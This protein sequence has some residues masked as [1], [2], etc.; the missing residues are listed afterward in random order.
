MH[1]Q[2]AFY[3]SDVHTDPPRCIDRATKVPP[4][5]TFQDGVY[6]NRIAGAMGHMQPIGT[7]FRHPWTWAGVQRAVIDR[8]LR[9]I[10]SNNVLPRRIDWQWS[11]REGL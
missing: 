6:M 2:A 4:L 5:S 10:L 11:R 3:V 1:C 8:A 7:L 9:R